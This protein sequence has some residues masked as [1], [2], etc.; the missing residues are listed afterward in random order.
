MDGPSPGGDVFTLTQV[1]HQHTVVQ[2]HFEVA[3]GQWIQGLILI[4]LAFHNGLAQFGGILLVRSAVG[5]FQTVSNVGDLADVVTQVT[6]NRARG[7]RRV[8]VQIDERFE[9][10]LVAG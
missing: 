10:A 4:V 1:V 3:G 8:P 7:L 5:L 9:R 2:I 6:E